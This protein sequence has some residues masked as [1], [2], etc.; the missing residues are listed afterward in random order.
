MYSESQNTNLDAIEREA[1]NQNITSCGR[2]ETTDSMLNGM[3]QAMRQGTERTGRRRGLG[4]VDMLRSMGCDDDEIMNQLMK[5]YGIS[6]E[7]AQSL[8]LSD[9][10]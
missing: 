6:R 8:V 2:R 9:N 7:E 10:G 5:S 1:E 4:T 3:M